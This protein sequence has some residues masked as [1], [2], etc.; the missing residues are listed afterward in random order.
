M[1]ETSQAETRKTLGRI[2]TDTLCDKCG[3]NLYSQEVWRDERL[4][5]PIARCPECG[6]FQAA[7]KS[8]GT[9]NKWLQR[10]GGAM[11]IL[12]VLLLLAATF[13]HLISMF[14]L[15]CAAIDNY[16]RYELIG[17]GPSRE[18]VVVPLTDERLM[19]QLFLLGGIAL[20]SFSLGGLVAVGMWPAKR[21]GR[22][23]L[24]LLLPI[25]T[26]GL[27]LMLLCSDITYIK[28]MKLVVSVSLLALCVE[29][30]AMVAGFFL[31]RPLTRRL[32]RTIISPGLLQY[33][34]CLWIIDGLPAPPLK[35]EK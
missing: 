3:Y 10:F 1:T 25:I 21:H 13:L 29:L 23:W 34:T 20:T 18:N 2:E 16:F 15:T 22:Y 26:T 30:V 12:W 8:S 5:I 27:L 6:A 33:L 24:T 17:P 32:L 7:G 14:G 35:T 11:V 19:F 9:G 31:G 28:E 4:N